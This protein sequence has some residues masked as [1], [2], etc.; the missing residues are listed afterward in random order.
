MAL[1]NVESEIT[2]PQR[3]SGA[4]RRNKLSVKDT[5][6]ADSGTDK[7]SVRSLRQSYLACDLYMECSTWDS[8]QLI[9]IK[10]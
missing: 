9:R 6:T 1:C 7:V 3:S 2:E 10:Y 8:V 4:L 5:K